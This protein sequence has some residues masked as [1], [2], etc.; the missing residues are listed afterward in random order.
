MGLL[1]L[2]LPSIETKNVCHH[3][4]HHLHHH[5]GMNKVRILWKKFDVYCKGKVMQVSTMNGQDTGR[6][7]FKHCGT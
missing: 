3:H 4:H 6:S 1:Y 2:C 7:S 5:N